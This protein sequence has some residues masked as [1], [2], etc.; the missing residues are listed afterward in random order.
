MSN[1][2][3]SKINFIVNYIK[4]YPNSYV[5]L[6]QLAERFSFGGY[7]KI[8][9]QGYSYLSKSLKN[10][11][12]GKAIFSGLMESKVT[13]VGN[14]FP[15]MI[16]LNESGVKSKVT[17]SQNKYTLVDFWYSH[18]GP[19][20]A[21]FPALKELYANYKHKGFNI[22]GISVDKKDYEDDWH[23]AIKKHGL[24][25]EQLLDKNGKNADRLFINSY[26]TTFLLDSKGKIIKRK[27]KSNELKTFLEKNL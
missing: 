23:E 12:T 26:P 4:Q 17:F 6:W 21:E 16:L 2:S 19:C 24:V 18:C 1:Y 5:G 11:T 27:I 14:N 8:Y 7:N 10:T 20:I 9:E 15:A 25:W 3:A 22:I 13:A